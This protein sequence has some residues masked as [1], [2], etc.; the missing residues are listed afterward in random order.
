ME[1]FIYLREEEVR[2]NIEMKLNT[3]IEFLT[4]KKLF[5]PFDMLIIKKILMSSLFLKDFN[6]DVIEYNQRKTVNDTDTK[7]NPVANFIKGLEKYRENKPITEDERKQILDNA[8][9]ADNYF[10]MWSIKTPHSIHDLIM[11][12]KIDEAIKILKNII[13]D[14]RITLNLYSFEGRYLERIKPG[15]HK[16]IE[17]EDIKTYLFYS[18]LELYCKDKKYNKTISKYIQV[19]FYKIKI[20]KKK[21]KDEA[22]LI[23]EIKKITNAPGKNTSKSYNERKT[24]NIKDDIKIKINNIYQ[25]YI[26]KPRTKKNEAIDINVSALYEQIKNEA[27]ALQNYLVKKEVKMKITEIIEIM[28]E[29][30]KTKKHCYRRDLEKKGLYILG[31]AQIKEIQEKRKEIFTEKLK[32]IKKEY[33]DGKIDKR[34]YDDFTARYKYRIENT[35][36]KFISNRLPDNIKNLMRQPTQLSKEIINEISSFENIVE[37]LNSKFY[38]P[39]IDYSKL[40]EYKNKFSNMQIKGLE[41]SGMSPEQLCRILVL[42]DLTKFKIYRHR[43]KPPAIHIKAQP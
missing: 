15:N 31:K 28:L 41:K 27:L 16:G 22:Y 36:F 18:L 26:A 33:R 6:I 14:E 20:G 13:S 21:D 3:I 35:F 9:N 38:I 19:L 42:A 11:D 1:T 23:K 4:N 34:E 10:M 32:L 24:D 5:D 7:I 12:E 8:L 25:D 37:L 39:V 40:V 17:V 29:E 30:A 2:K 43:I